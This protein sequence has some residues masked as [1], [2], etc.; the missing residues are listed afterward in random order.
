MLNWKTTFVKILLVKIP[1]YSI[2]QN[3]APSNICAIRYVTLH[4]S[5]FPFFDV[6]C[7][8]KNIFECKKGS[9]DWQ[10]PLKEET[11][12]KSCTYQHYL[13]YQDFIPTLAFVT[14]TFI[15]ILLVKI[16]QSRNKTLIDCIGNAWFPPC[17]LFLN[18]TF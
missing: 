6:Y 7:I 18:S 12:W 5:T 11:R 1:D 14:Y 9:R 4:Y 17:F 16:S 15:F 13:I 8:Y 10:L 2:R 3:F